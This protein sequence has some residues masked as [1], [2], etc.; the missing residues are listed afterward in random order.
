MRTLDLL[1]LFAVTRIIAFHVTANPILGAIPALP[2]MFFTAGYLMARSLSHSSP[3]TVLP[4]RF[5]RIMLPYWVYLVAIVVV[6]IRRG[7]ASELDVVDWIG[8]IVPPL[9]PTGLEGPG[10]GTDLEMTWLALWYIEVQ[11]ILVL[12]SPL[13]FPLFRRFPR[14]MLVGTAALTLASSVIYVQA[15]GVFGVL[16]FWLFGF[17]YQHNEIQPL[18]RK[19]TPAIVVVS[20]P[21]VVLAAARGILPDGISDSASAVSALGGVGI[22]LIAIVVAW[23]VIEWFDAKQWPQGSDAMLT[24]MSSRLM[25]VYLWHFLIIYWIVTWRP[26]IGSNSILLFV[27]TLAGTFIACIV[28]GWIED[29]ASGKKPRVLLRR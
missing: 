18:L 1:R 5:R 2:L 23:P 15:T 24:W 10:V 21:F 3:R 11:L 20:L 13:L 12:L 28:F 6:W 14:G 16:L 9:S 8:F 25:T 19:F 4:R 27:L 26:W 29:I 7:A 17:G 22:A